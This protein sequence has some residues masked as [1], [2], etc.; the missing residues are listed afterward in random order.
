[1]LTK[2]IVISVIVGLACLSLTLIILNSQRCKECESTNEKFT[3]T[4]TPLIVTNA[5]AYAPAA[6]TDERGFYTD[7][8]WLLRRI[9]DNSTDEPGI[10]N[11]FKKPKRFRKT[12][13]FLKGLIG[14]GLK[15]WKSF[16]TKYSKKFNNVEA[17]RQRI[18]NFITVEE[19]IDAHNEDFKH[20][21]S[22]F[23]VGINEIA[24]L[25]FSE[26]KKLNGFRFSEARKRRSVSRNKNSDLL[27]QY[28]NGI[29]DS[30]DW[31][32]QRVTQVRNQGNC[33]SCWAFAAVGALEGQ[34]RRKKGRLLSFS[35]QHLIDCSFM[36]CD[37]G[38]T[39]KARTQNECRINR[40]DMKA[41]VYDYVELFEGDEEA[42]KYAVATEGPVAVA[43]DTDNRSFQLYKEGVY[44]EPDCASSPE[45][46]DH[47]VLVVGY[48][49][50]K[51]SG[52]EYW[53]VKNSWGT[54][55]GMD[56][57]IYMARNQK[58]L[59]GIASEASYPLVR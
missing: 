4:Y 21:N 56:G 7:E 15:D 12:R 43:I 31:R 47:A 58:N 2:A 38:W 27:R 46:L 24:D 54:S 11:G 6:E 32:E 49:T 48:G 5:P 16:K 1:M 8:E 22:S 36:N 45:L 34:Y 51:K 59:C 35:A 18:L 20:G 25:P 33:G 17:E 13:A 19:Y 41:V 44:Y 29:P 57:Y 9:D 39:D 14:K 53:I 42:L 37:G 28:L 26:Y 30:I 23:K 3:D 55:W 10:P 40:S 52:M 50:D